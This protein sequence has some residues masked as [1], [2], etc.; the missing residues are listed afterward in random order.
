MKAVDCTA[1]MVRH[2]AENARHHGAEAEFAVMDSH[3]LAYP[4]QSFDLVLSRNVTWTLRDPEAAYR[5]WLRVLR[6]GG[7]LLV[8]DANWYR[9]MLDEEA[10]RA[11]EAAEKAACGK[12][13]LTPFKEP[14]PALLE[15]IYMSMPM[16]KRL[17]P[18]WDLQFL[19][20]CGYQKTEVEYGLEDH[21]WEDW[22]QVL[23]R[24]TPMFMVKA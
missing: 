17:R 3:S 10:R 22:E 12:L 5:E 14:D 24:S 6:P 21:I 19:A 2:A 4:D 8:F 9:Y 18:E 1:E 7:R 16:G 20:S 13:G 15:Q 11:R 23:D